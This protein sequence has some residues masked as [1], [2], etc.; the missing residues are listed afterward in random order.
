MATIAD[1]LNDIQNLQNEMSSTGIVHKEFGD[2]I[3]V[4]EL[5]NFTTIYFFELL[6]H[7]TLDALRDHSELIHHLYADKYYSMYKESD[8]LQQ[9]IRMHNIS[10]TFV[11]W[12]IFERHIDK[13]REDLPEA[14]EGTLEV[15]YK[16]VLKGFGI[17]KQLYDTMINE[18]N[19]I[20]LTRNS[21]HCGGIFRNKKKRTFMLKGEKYSLKTGQ[22]VT[23]LRL[24]D[25]AETMWKHFV[26]VADSAKPSS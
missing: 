12:N 7:T 20:R 1:T 14:P 2:S 26:I 22:E 19:L 23:P 4:Q 10:G 21:L 6:A 18:F 16:K 15:R 8:M 17:E 11:L 9:L 25:V 24:M 5:M 13:M 3:F